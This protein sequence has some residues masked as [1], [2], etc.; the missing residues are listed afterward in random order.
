MRC[1]ISCWV[2][3]PARQ[4]DTCGAVLSDGKTD[5][6]SVNDGRIR[7]AKLILLKV[8]KGKKHKGEAGSPL[9]SLRALQLDQKSLKSTSSV[10]ATATA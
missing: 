5:G 4:P 1:A 3:L 10:M 8:L 6:R 9:L 2:N 7:P